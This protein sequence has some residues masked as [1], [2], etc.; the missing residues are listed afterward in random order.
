[1]LSNANMGHLERTRT[2]QRN[3][4]CAN[5]LCA[6]KQS[7]FPH[8]PSII[9]QAADR[10][11]RGH[12]RFGTRPDYHQRF[13]RARLR[14]L[15]APLNWLR[16]HYLFS[17]CSCIPPLCRARPPALPLPVCAAVRARSTLRDLRAR[18]TLRDLAVRFERR[19]SVRVTDVNLTLL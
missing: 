10:K 3:A 9:F 17:R 4:C 15:G 2:R 7:L 13:Q 14:R 8:E 1:M 5:R 19:R 11:P 6:S 18:S 12:P 16:L